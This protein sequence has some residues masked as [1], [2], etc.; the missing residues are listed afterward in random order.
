MSNQTKY[1]CGCINQVTQGVLGSISKCDLHCSMQHDPCKMSNVESRRYYGNNSAIVD[2][3][4]QCK[5]YI[6][7]FVECVGEVPLVRHNAYAIEIGCGLSMYVPMFLRK[8]YNY[9]GIEPNGYA[10][11][12]TSSTYDVRVTRGEFNDVYTSPQLT[13]VVLAAHCI[14]HMKDPLLCFN[15]VYE[16]LV[17][18]GLFYI[19]VPNDD[20]PV[21]PDHLWFFTET[22]LTKA[23]R[24]AGFVVDTMRTVRRI[25]RER[26]IYCKARKV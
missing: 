5:S 2:G 20:D 24:S 23:L 13:D 4:P 25:E 8:G 22:S 7:E 21:N 12:W 11:D 6:A 17:S 10:A 15:K 3:I 26:F 1:P 14:E 18:A 19:I 9:L 16:M